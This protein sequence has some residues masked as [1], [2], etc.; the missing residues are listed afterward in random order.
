V[1][2]NLSDPHWAFIWPAYVI[3]AAIFASLIATTMWRLR[4][5]ARAARNLER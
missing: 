3:T 4:K 1:I 2:A 5:W